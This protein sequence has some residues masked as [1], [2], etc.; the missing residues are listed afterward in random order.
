ML[1]CFVDAMTDRG[2]YL[3]LCPEKLMGDTLWKYLSAA[4]EQRFGRVGGQ[5]ASGPIDQ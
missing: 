5:F 1:P 3:D 4:F 2:A